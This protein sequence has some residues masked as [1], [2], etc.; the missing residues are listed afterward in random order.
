VLLLELEPVRDPRGDFTVTWSRG[1]FEK[2]GIRADF[3]QDAVAR[4]RKNVLRGLH[5]QVKEAQGK[6][7]RAS[8][9]EI[10]DVAVD[11]RR[12]SPTFGKWVAERLSAQNRRM[13]WIPPGFAHGYL[14]LSEGADVE[15]KIA[16]AYAP[17]HERSIRW[18]DPDLAIGW[19][20]EGAPILSAR[21]A[22]GTTFA[23]AETYAQ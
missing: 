6:L 9:G 2:L 20:V 14:V 18:D 10:Y 13:L 8:A 23:R 7:V 21:D 16:G 12:S 15:Y 11:L 19:P 4:S 5:Y 1:E 3:A 17:E 22:A